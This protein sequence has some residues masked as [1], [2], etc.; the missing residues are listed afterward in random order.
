VAVATAPKMSGPPPVALLPATIV[1]VRFRVLVLLAVSSR[2]P[3]PRVAA[4][5]L[6][7]VQFSRVAVP[8]KMSRPLRR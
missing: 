4:E 2:M 3:P 8:E 7:R 6:L 5:L 1:F